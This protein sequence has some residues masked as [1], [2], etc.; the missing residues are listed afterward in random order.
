M[1]LALAGH[2][3][4]DSG[5]QRHSA[6]FLLTERYVI[7][8][9]IS[10]SFSPTEVFGLADSWSAWKQHSSSLNRLSVSKKNKPSPKVN[11][12]WNFWH[13]FQCLYC[14]IHRH[15]A[16]AKTALIRIAS[17]GAKILCTIP[18]LTIVWCSRWFVRVVAVMWE[19]RLF[20][21]PRSLHAT[22]RQT[23]TC[24]RRCVTEWSYLA[25]SV[26]RN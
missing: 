26:R 11:C 1:A 7:S 4:R 19:L 8:S 9:S 10:W 12:A 25:R 21:P 22:D 15:R 3:P 24:S 20:R 23:D 2:D 5:R 18:L 13:K 17:C 6:A 14:L 16:T